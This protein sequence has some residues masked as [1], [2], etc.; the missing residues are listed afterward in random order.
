MRVDHRDVRSWLDE[1]QRLWRTHGTSELAEIFAPSATYSM[2]P[3]ATPHCG[4]SAIETM[5]DAER[6]SADEVFTMA[7]SIVAVEERTAVVRV[8]VIYGAPT[9]RQ[10][11]DLWVIQFAPDGQC[12]S[13]AE[14][15]F[16]P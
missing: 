16:W 10:Y 6:E 14:W 12:I 5:W 2:A 15:P 4:L 1:Y 7:A 11:R 8:E 9:R 13:F 3:F